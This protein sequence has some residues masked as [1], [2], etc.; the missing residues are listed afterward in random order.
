MLPIS[1]PPDWLFIQIDMYL[2]RFEIF[3]DAPRSQLAS[4][5]RLFVATPRRFHV[6]RLHVIDP[7][8]PSAQRFH[9]AESFEDV[10]SP[11]GSRQPIGRIIGDLDRVF[12]ILEGD[13][14]R[15]RAEDFLAS[16]TGSI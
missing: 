1:V 5:T 4:K 13:N 3:L 6:G 12:F 7:D 10:P 16:D 8:D 15:D 2:L 14:R 9:C 11:D